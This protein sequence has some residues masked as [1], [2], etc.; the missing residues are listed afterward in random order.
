MKT[1][2]F[3][4]EVLQ[5]LVGISRQTLRYWRTNLDCLP[6]RARFTAK[7]ILVYWIFKLLIKNRHVHVQELQQYN[8]SNLFQW[9]QDNSFDR[10]SEHLLVLDDVTNTVS[11][12]SADT[13]TDP[14]DIHLYVLKLA[15]AVSML[16]DSFENH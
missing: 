14:Y 16:L 7:V 12:V 5:Q 6:T 1:Q 8:L 13:I 15:P 9:V 4:P 11:F 2:G 10:I 3:K